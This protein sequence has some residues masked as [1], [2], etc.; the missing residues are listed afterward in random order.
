MSPPGADQEDSKVLAAFAARDDLSDY[1]DNGLLLFSL[2]LRHGVEDIQGVA[3]TA[4]TD[5]ANDKKCDL[6]YVDRGAG[7]VIVAQAHLSRDASKTEAPANKAS[8]LNTAVGWLIAGDL[9]LLPRTSVQQR[10]RYVTPS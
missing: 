5:G 6:V 1:G 7:R 9:R 2:Q 8:D 3:A 4:L 10:R